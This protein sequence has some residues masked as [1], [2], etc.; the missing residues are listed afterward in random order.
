MEEEKINEVL[1]TAEE[2]MTVFTGKR[3]ES[4]DYRVFRKVRK[5]LNKSLKL[6]LGGKY[7]HIS[8]VLPNMSNFKDMPEAKGTY[9]RTEL[10]RHEGLGRKCHNV[11][12]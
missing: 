4:M 10:R 11:S 2:Q 5:D 1:V 3:P 9:V 6:Y 8:V 12:N 7:K